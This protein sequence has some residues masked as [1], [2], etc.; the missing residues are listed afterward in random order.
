MRI[1]F[2]KAW[3]IFQRNF[4]LFSYGVQI[5]LL[6]AIVGT[7]C[8]FLIGLLAG[9]VRAIE[10]N[11]YDST[12]VKVLKRIGKLLTGFYIWVFRGTPMMV[13]AMFIFHLLRQV[14]NWSSMTAALFI[15]SINTGAYMAEIIR[16]GIQSVDVGQ[17]EAAKSIGMTTT[18]TLVSVIFPQAI[19]NTFPSIGNQLI[20][21][22]KDSSML[23]VISVTELYFQTTSVAGSNY[24]YIETFLVSAIIYLFLTTISTFILN[25][26]E[27]RM[28]TVKQTKDFCS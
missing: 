13:Q 11:D 6:F 7:V 10:I 2:A 16:A 28:N 20:V 25:Y 9:G 5:T 19:K 23:N 18:Q 22:I 26:I 24:K 12:V 3:E 4:S 1:D 15:I 14:I 27:K 8:G 21:N 17:T